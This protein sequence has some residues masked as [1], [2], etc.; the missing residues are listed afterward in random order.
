MKWR[1]FFRLLHVGRQLVAGLWMCWYIFPR[2]SETEKHARIQNWAEGMLRALGI[3]L[4][5]KGKPASTGPLLLVANHISWADI[6]I[7]HASRHCRFISKDS[8]GRWPLIGRLARASGTLF[9]TRESRRDALRV[10][11]QMVECLRGGEVLA[12][13]PEGTT[14]DGHA[15]LPFHAN[16]LQAAITANAPIQPIALRFVDGKTGVNNFA[17]CYKGRDTL[18]QSLW[19]TLCTD[20]MVAL[21][22]FAEPEYAQGRDRRAWAVDLQRTIETML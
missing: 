11:H 1:A 15:L 17:P 5:V 9:I 19:R 13:F 18:L 10:V 3:R 16:L 14:G 4:Q 2:L 7:L 8:V 12:V 22:E 21:V 6:V 20:D